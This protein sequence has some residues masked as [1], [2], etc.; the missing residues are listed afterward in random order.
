M[1]RT[2]LQALQPPHSFQWPFLPCVR[3]RFLIS[4][5][6]VLFC[7]LTPLYP[8]LSL[9]PRFRVELLC[10]GDFTDN[11]SLFFQ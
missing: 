10:S 6:D 4:K 8:F 9:I 5:S 3:L 11:A 2:E 7:L 1:S